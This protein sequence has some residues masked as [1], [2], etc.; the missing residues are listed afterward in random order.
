MIIKIDTEKAEQVLETT[1]QKYLE[2]DQQMRDLKK[3][4]IFARDFLKSVLTKVF[5]CMLI[6]DKFDEV[7]EMASEIYWAKKEFES[8]ANTSFRLATGKLLNN[9]RSPKKQERICSFCGVSYIYLAQNYGEHRHRFSK[10]EDCKK[11]K[12][13]SNVDMQET[14]ELR[15]QKIQELRTMP[16]ADYLNTEHWKKTRQWAL[17]RAGHRCQLCNAKSPLDV[18]HRTYE[19][20]GCEWHSDLIALCRDCHE[21]FHDECE[22]AKD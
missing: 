8:I 16:Y 3:E 7:V 20:R 21:I 6:Q 10:C 17:K 12:D 1:L 13:E 15:R 2:M 4:M 18:H 22:L 14:V 11:R 5:K 9:H 19:R